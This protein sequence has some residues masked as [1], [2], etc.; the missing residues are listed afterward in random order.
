[1][2]D[3]KIEWT[4]KTWNPVTGCHKISPGCK[5]CYADRLFPKVYPGRKFED[6]RTHDD[7]LNQPLSWKTPQ[8]VFVDSM[9]DL[10]H[11]DVPFEFIDQCFAVM[12]LAE[13]HTF[14]VLTKR[15][16]RMREYFNSIRPHHSENTHADTRE[17]VRSWAAQ[18]WAWVNRRGDEDI[19]WPLPNVW[20]G[21]STEDQETFDERVE[22]LAACPAVV[23][24]VSAEP[25]LGD[26]DVGNAFDDPPDGSTY[27]KIHWVIAGGE[28]GPKARPS[29]PDWFRYLRDQCANAGTPFFFKQ[30]GEWASTHPEGALSPH[31]G[32]CSPI[33]HTDFITRNASYKS[34][35]EPTM[36]KG[37]FALEKEGFAFMH[38]IGK[39]KAGRLLDD[40]LHDEYPE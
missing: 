27:G 34:D 8:R 25:L 35:V 21:T 5:H 36:S 18:H 22:H 37:K 38:R 19:R 10:F 9:G 40:R 6:V 14:Q 1:M 17:I 39:Q 12:A 20:L 11:K 13:Q 3:S 30:W 16:D 28:S 32:W 4:N 7:R 33:A 15:A 29:H 23:R 2:G 24:F 31:N 26:I